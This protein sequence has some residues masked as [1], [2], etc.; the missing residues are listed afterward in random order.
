MGKVIANSM[1]MRVVEA[2][3]DLGYEATVEPNSPPF[4]IFGWFRG[5]EFK[6]DVVVRRQDKSAVVVARS[7]PAIMYDVFLTDQV[8]QKLGTNNAGALI[9]VEDSAFSRVRKSSKEYAEDLNV[10]LCPLSEVG[11]VLRELL[12]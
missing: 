10:R 9:C 1:E 2:A 7:S 8:R 5:R 3:N 11:D 6:P 12:G 4:R